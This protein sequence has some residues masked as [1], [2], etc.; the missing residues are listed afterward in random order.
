MAEVRDVLHLIEDEFEPHM[1]KIC[2]LRDLYMYA[3]MAKKKCSEITDQEVPPGLF[4][5]LD[6]AA[7]AYIE[8]MRELQKMAGEREDNARVEGKP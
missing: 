1:D 8:I 4:R 3:E 7:D 2:L 5:I 6:E